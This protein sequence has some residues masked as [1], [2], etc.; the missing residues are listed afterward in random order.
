[1]SDAVRCSDFYRTVAPNWTAVREVSSFELRRGLTLNGPFQ[2]LGD[3]FTISRWARFAQRRW[4]LIGVDYDASSW[5]VK[6]APS[7]RNKIIAD[8]NITRKQILV[9]GKTRL[10]YPLLVVTVQLN[11]FKLIPYSVVGVFTP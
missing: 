7:F 4:G 10:F 5:F 6:P 9:S 11:R 3:T 8:G 2:S 1:M